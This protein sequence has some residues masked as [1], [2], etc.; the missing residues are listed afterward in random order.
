MQVGEARKQDAEDLP[1]E[2]CSTLIPT[3]SPQNYLSDTCKT[4][5]FHDI[6]NMFATEYFF[7]LLYKLLDRPVI[8]RQDTLQITQKIAVKIIIHVHN[9]RS[10]LIV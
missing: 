9:R 1:T 10:K 8:V 2:S 5:K 3:K 4:F 7:Y 6:H